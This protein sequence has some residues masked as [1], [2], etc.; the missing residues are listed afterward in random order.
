M[1]NY[2]HSVRESENSFRCSPYP[3]GTAAHARRKNVAL[4]ITPSVDAKGSCSQRTPS[5]AQL[6]GGWIPGRG[7]HAVGFQGFRS[8][9]IGFRHRRLHCRL[10]SDVQ[11]GSTLWVVRALPWADIG[12]DWRLQHLSRPLG[13]CKWLVRRLVPAIRLTS[14]RRCGQALSDRRRHIAEPIS[15]GWVLTVGGH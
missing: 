8:I 11:E 14:A 15:S 10:Q 2:F 1:L 6:R 5:C 12:P 7:S 4:D 9:R 13:S 3:R